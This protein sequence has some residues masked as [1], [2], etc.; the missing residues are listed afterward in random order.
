MFCFSYL[1]LLSVEFT[2]VS[3][4]PTFPSFPFFPHLFP[5]VK[6]AISLPTPGHCVNWK[7]ELS[8]CQSVSRLPCEQW[9]LQVGRFVA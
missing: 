4:V 7:V 6:K 5:T 2:P 8:S 9:F 1:D 3:L